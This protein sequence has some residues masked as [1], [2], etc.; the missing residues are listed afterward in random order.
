MIYEKDNIFLAQIFEEAQAFDSIKN[1]FFTY[2]SELL[3]YVEVEWRLIGSGL[4]PVGG[5][6]ID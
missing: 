2:N 3:W 1:R 6:Y 4:S 5:E